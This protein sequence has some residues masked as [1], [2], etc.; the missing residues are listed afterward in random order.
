MIYLTVM[1]IDR[2]Q[3]VI[4]GMRSS[5][6]IVEQDGFWLEGSDGTGNRFE[7]AP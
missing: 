3:R 6:T 7:S 4:A 1:Q 5:Q 2:S